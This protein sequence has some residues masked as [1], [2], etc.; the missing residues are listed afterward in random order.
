MLFLRKE[1][2]NYSWAKLNRILVHKQTAVRPNQLPE[3]PTL[4]G[5]DRGPQLPHLTNPFW[6]LLHWYCRQQPK[7]DWKISGEKERVYLGVSW[8]S[9]QRVK[10]N[11]SYFR[12]QVL[13]TCLTGS[14]QTSLLSWELIYVAI[15]LFYWRDQAMKLHVTEAAKQ[16]DCL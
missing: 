1:I 4:Y 16:G 3:H 2:W 11:S 12:H 10:F 7:M 6:L 13:G 9:P 15:G 8:K 14:F 5:V